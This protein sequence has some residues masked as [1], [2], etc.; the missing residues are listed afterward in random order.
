M[1]EICVYDADFSFL[2]ATWPLAECLCLVLLGWWVTRV[3]NGASF[4]GMSLTSPRFT[5]FLL[6]IIGENYVHTVRV[7]AHGGAIIRARFPTRPWLWAQEVE[8]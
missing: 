2:A 3:F 8:E 4:P 1:Y 5:S 6:L 7:H